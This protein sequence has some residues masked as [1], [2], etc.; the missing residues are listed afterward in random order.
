MQAWDYWVLFQK[1]IQIQVGGSDQQGNIHFGVQLIK[2]I[3]K[4]D[5]RNEMAPK[6]NEDPHLKLP[7]GVTTPLITTSTGVKL[8]K[9]D[10]NA[11]W[12]DGDMTSPFDFYQVPTYCNFCFL[13]WP[14][15]RPSC[16]IVVGH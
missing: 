10:G 5:P 6:K 11:V 16:S 14:L 4:N 9:S 12:L 7:I 2:D 15:G 3:L 8:G 13:S 1:G